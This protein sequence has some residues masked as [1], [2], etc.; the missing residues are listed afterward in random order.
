MLEQIGIGKNFLNRTPMI[1]PL[2]ERMIKWEC[3]KLKN[4]CTAEETGPR[5]TR[6]PTE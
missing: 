1:Q 4:F 5:L 6:L 3:I 2:R